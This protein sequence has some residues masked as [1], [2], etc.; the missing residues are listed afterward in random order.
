[1]TRIC[2]KCG[3]LK[4]LEEFPTRNNGQYYRHECK[5]C[6][7]AR[8]IEY[9]K[10]R[11]KALSSIIP[12]TEVE[13]THK[14]CITC[15]NLKT[16]EHFFYVPSQGNYMGKCILC[17]REYQNNDHN[18]SI[19]KEWRDRNPEVVRSYYSTYYANNAEYIMARTAAYAKQ[20]FV[21]AK[22]YSLRYRRKNIIA[23]RWRSRIYAHYWRLRNIEK[24]RIYSS[25][26]RNRYLA[27]P[28]RYTVDD[29]DNH[30]IEQLGKC[31]YCGVRF[32]A[33]NYHIDH[34]IPLT[35]EGTSNN[36]SNLQ[37]LCRSCNCSKNNKTHEE[38]LQYLEIL[39]QAA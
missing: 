16:I 27:H 39:R 36:A 24:S 33:D 10:R 30:F 22:K 23:V 13:V 7:S 20:D 28:K 35:R 12:R 18:K 9:N 4:L 11:P 25:E 6:Y 3:A 37:L 5:L 17:Y 26:R 31:I 32:V 38:F 8:F 14:V 15:G 21:K 19:R 29:I 1:M 34:I 2:K